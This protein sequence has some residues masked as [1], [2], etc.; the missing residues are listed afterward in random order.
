MSSLSESVKTDITV[1]VA[2]DGLVHR[3]YA[4]DEGAFDLR[5]TK[6]D[7]GQVTEDVVLLC[8][9]LVSVQAVTRTGNQV[10]CMKCLGT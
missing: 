2:H 6:Y 7:G 10:N 1:N 9:R 4:T 5:F 8:G 3:A